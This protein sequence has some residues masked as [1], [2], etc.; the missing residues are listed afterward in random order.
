LVLLCVDMV[1]HIYWFVCTEPSPY[2]WD[3]FHL[4]TVNNLF[5]VLLYAQMNN[6]TIKK[7]KNKGYKNNL[8]K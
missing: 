6:K 4:T 7:L 8:K 2:L 5:N 3:E 1:Y